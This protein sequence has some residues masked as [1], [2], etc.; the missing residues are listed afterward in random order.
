[1]C[2]PYSTRHQ[3]YILA[4]LVRDCPVSI[5]GEANRLCEIRREGQ[6]VSPQ[7][8]AHKAVCSYVF[9]RYKEPWYLDALKCLCP[10]LPHQ[11]LLV[12]KAIC[13]EV[14]QILYSENKI[15][16]SR[17]CNGGLERLLHVSVTAI[18]SLTSL[19]VR[20]DLC[21]CPSK[22][23]GGVCQL[24]SSGCTRKQEHNIR[25]NAE[26]ID[27]WV[28]ICNRI[29]FADLIQPD[30]LRLDLVCVVSVAG[31]AG[32][33]G[34]WLSSLPK[35]SKC[36]LRL[37]RRSDKG[38]R[39]LAKL[40]VLRSVKRIQRQEIVPFRFLDLPYEIQQRILLQT[41][42]IASGPVHFNAPTGGR[43]ALLEM[44]SGGEFRCC[45]MCTEGLET[46]CCFRNQ[47][48]FSSSGCECWRFPLSIL[49]TCHTLY[50]EGFKIFWSRN[51]FRFTHYEYY[52]DDTYAE[53][54][55][56]KALALPERLGDKALRR[57]RNLTIEIDDDFY[58][59]EDEFI[60][61]CMQIVL[62]NMMLSN[63]IL[64]IR[65]KNRGSLDE[66]EASILRSSLKIEQLRG[67]KDFQFYESTFN[68]RHEIPRDEH[69]EFGEKV[70]LEILG[71]RAEAGGETR[72]QAV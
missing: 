54:V 60:D 14:L 47:S 23:D 8:T 71:S 29:R 37:S 26:A 18:A 1:M 39:W 17:N 42:L 15:V 31:S 11:L 30:Q 10:S 52:S 69:S 61:D 27:E 63:L 38:L 70:R 56:I 2:L 45:Y 34:H 24:D 49:K 72:K 16:I 44:H 58:F 9:K 7:R 67:L 51:H 35:L 55:D 22:C 21:P 48:A 46:C 3:I 66:D 50:E 68:S 65:V 20:L 64:H 12:S 5:N 13:S 4:G 6:I 57:I 53:P 62:Q 43:K 41:D 32:Q 25:D 40:F 33:I 36:A 59:P 19:T 28:E